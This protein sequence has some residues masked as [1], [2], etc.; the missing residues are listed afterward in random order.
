MADTKTIRIKT[1]DY[2]PLGSLPL[3]GV[4]QLTDLPRGVLFKDSR[5]D[6]PDGAK[7]IP[8]TQGKFVLVDA[9]DYAQL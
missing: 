3:F 7:L 6:C 2:A 5:M 4:C 9:D 8:L 1:L